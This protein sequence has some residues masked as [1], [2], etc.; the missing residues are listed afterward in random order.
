MRSIADSQFL[1]NE[2]LALQSR[3]ETIRPF[4]LTMP[5]VPAAAI[6]DQALREISNLLMEGHAQ[7][8]KALKEFLQ[9][10]R[11][12]LQRKIPADQVQ[13]Q[14]CMLKLRFNALLDQ[15]DIF[16]DVLSQRSEHIIGVLIAG[17]DVLAEDVLNVKLSNFQKPPMI[18]FV[19]R[20]HGAAIRRARTRLPGGM[21]NPVAVIQVPRERMIGSG[22]ASSLIHEAGHQGA[23]LLHLTETIRKELAVKINGRNALAWTCFH[24]WLSEIIADFW[25]IAHLGIGATVGLM[26]VVS[27]PKYFMYRINNLDDPHPFPWIRVKT[28]LAFGAVLFPH[29]QWH[30]YQRLWE[31]LYPTQDLPQKVKALLNELLLV[32]PEFVELVV[33]HRSP[34]TEGKKLRDLFPVTERQ[35]AHLQHLYTNW[36]FDFSQ[37]GRASPSLVFAVIGQARADNAIATNTEV[38][39]LRTWLTNWAL[40]R[41]E[42]RP[43]IEIPAYYRDVQKIVHQ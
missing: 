6:S 4:S 3:L 18:C 34:Y 1:Y 21:L 33:Q 40:Q 31:S 20:G 23:A 12:P 25:A 13:A 43:K 14:F 24:R 11:D 35:P 38:K 36:R 16:A 29:L 37:I 32:L 9:L 39:L 7:L 26:N 22:I 42:K 2:A 15:L 28:S 10:V 30:R 41:S 27:L 17:L 8:R 19:E 5:M